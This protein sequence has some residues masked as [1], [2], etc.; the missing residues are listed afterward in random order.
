MIENSALQVVE[1]QLI[2]YNNR[3]IES[4]LKYYHNDIEMYTLSG[5]LILKGIESLRQRYVER[6]KNE[7]LHCHIAKRMIL[8]N[9]IID[10]EEIEGM[11]EDGLHKVIVVYEIRDDRV[12]RLTV[13]S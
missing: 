9:K 6:F 12:A 2:A 4:F 8:G 11:I 7:K 13:I 3:D 10:Y 1:G 5:D